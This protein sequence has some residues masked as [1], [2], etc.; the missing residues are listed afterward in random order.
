MLAGR[1]CSQIGKMEE[2]QSVRVLIIED[3]RDVASYIRQ[4]LTQAGWNV[5]VANDGKDGLLLA[6][7][8]NYDALVVDRMLPGVEGLT[9]IRTLRASENET[10]ALVLSALGVSPFDIVEGLK[11]LAM[12]IYNAG[13]DTFVWALN[14]WIQ[15]T[16]P[17]V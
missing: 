9:L 10:P 13:F 5:D 17:E 8:E 2:R 14:D 6:T 12:R 1:L 4:G 3:D 15:V 11:R 16:G 7:T